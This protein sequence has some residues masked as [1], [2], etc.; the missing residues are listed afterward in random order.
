M[1]TN[2]L[3]FEKIV[4]PAFIHQKV[5][6]SERFFSFVYTR[7]VLEMDIENIDISYTFH[8]NSTANQDDLE[9]GTKVEGLLFSVMDV[10]SLLF[11]L[12]N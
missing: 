2:M 8:Q 1:H 12:L 7:M 3:V 4:F 5:H 10:Y 11:H 9:K 6:F